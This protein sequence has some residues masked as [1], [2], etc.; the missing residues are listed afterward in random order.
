MDKR[1]QIV[2][3]YDFLTTIA[4]SRTTFELGFNRE[5]RSES[6]LLKAAVAHVGGVLTRPGDREYEL[7]R[8]WILDGA[9]L[10][11]E[12][13]GHEHRAAS[14]NPIRRANLLQQML[15]IATYSDGTVRDVTSTP[16]LKGTS[17]YCR[18]NLPGS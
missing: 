5:S 10:D 14:Q 2:A 16:L 1:I 3:G 4:R 12:S 6:L 11:L 13:C 9:K 8:Q 15:V 17:R 18:R 7:L